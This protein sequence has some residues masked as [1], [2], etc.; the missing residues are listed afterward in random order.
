MRSFTITSR[1][2]KP[3]ATA[4]TPALHF[5]ALTPFTLPFFQVRW[6]ATSLLSA[7]KIAEGEPP[8]FLPMGGAF[9]N[10]RV[11]DPKKQE[12]FK[13][14]LKWADYVLDRAIQSNETMAD[15]GWLKIFGIGVSTSRAA[16]FLSVGASAF[17]FI[18]FELTNWIITKLATPVEVLMDE[19]LAANPNAT[20]G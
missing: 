14:E 20:L 4:R 11:R 1:C 18:G 5:L 10:P 3:Y 17:A 9:D 2:S 8:D 12:Q 16:T 13:E 6:E 15:G 19:Y 7:I